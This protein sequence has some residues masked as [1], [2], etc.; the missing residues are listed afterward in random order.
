MVGLQSI[1]FLVTFSHLLY[2]IRSWKLKTYTTIKKKLN[3]WVAS[4][5]FKTWIMHFIWSKKMA[6]SLCK[7]M[8]LLTLFLWRKFVGPFW[9][10]TLWE[11]VSHFTC[12]VL[13]CPGKLILMTRYSKTV[14][15]DVY[16]SHICAR[17]TYVKINFDNLNRNNLFK[18]E[19]NLNILSKN[20]SNFANMKA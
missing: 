5:Y 3:E 12:N 20:N 4:R 17:P 18:F 19:W 9:N 15:R 16:Y 1:I 10:Y 14:Y 13:C 7:I 2:V 8:M 11:I 6:K